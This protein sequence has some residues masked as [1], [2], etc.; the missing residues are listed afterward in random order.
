MD[1]GSEQYAKVQKNFIELNLMEKPKFPFEN[2]S[3]ELIYSS[4]SIEHVND[5]AVENFIGEAF[6]ILTA[7]LSWQ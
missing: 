1:Y 4:H 2:E 3:I 5:T 6:R 7:I